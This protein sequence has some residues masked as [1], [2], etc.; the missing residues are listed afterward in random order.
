[1]FV[2][3]HPFALKPQWMD[4]YQIWYM[5]FARGRNQFLPN[6][7]SMGSGVQIRGGAIW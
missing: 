6:C 1:M 5:R 7:L 4:F 2:I 3:F